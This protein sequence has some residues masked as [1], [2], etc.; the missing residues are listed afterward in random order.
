MNLKLVGKE[1]ARKTEKG[2]FDKDKV[3]EAVFDK[4]TVMLLSRMIN[5]GIISY[6]NGAVGAG[7]ESQMYWAVDPSGQDL[8]V[9]IY[10]VTTSNFKKRY[11]YLIGDPRFTKIKKGTRSLV[12]LWAKK[13]FRNLSKSFN[14]GISCPEPITVMKNILVMKFVGSNGVP[15]PT[16]VESE[17]DYTDYGKTIEIISDLYQK[18]ELVHADL[19]EY[20]IFKTKTGPMVFDFGSAVDIRHP[21]TKEFLER[22]IS[23]ITRFFVKRGLTVDNPIDVFERVTK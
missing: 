16:L 19:S 17:V 10:L 3:L 1:R 22:D 14:A 4:S 13:E 6:V 9:K 7:K 18:A 8:A 12:E 5:K 2:I 11:P 15:S 20:N 23:N 21:K